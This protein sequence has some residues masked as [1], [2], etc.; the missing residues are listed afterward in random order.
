[1]PGKKP[2]VPSR[3]EASRVTSPTTW[4]S[5]AAPPMPAAAA[6]IA[7]GTLSMRTAR[8]PLRASPGVYWPRPQPRSRGRERPVSSRSGSAVMLAAAAV[9]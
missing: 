7:V 4:L 3:A 8:H 9:P 1:M 6:S 5:P 2:N